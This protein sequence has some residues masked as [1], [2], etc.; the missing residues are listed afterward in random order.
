MDISGDFREF[1]FPSHLQ[2]ARMTK[3]GVQLGKLVSLD[4]PLNA[5]QQLHKPPVLPPLAVHPVVELYV[6]YAL[7]RVKW[8]IES[9]NILAF[10]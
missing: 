4:H 6:P 9:V 1:L 2:P 5:A 3:W 10:F 7:W 8:G